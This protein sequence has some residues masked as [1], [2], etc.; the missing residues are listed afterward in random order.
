V[1]LEIRMGSDNEAI[2][3][4][5]KTIGELFK[6]YPHFPWPAD[7]NQYDYKARLEAEYQA[8]WARENPPSDMKG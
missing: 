2:K 3:A 5:L 1:W 4:A 8:E 7:P 6:K